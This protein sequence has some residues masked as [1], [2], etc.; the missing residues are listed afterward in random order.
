MKTDTKT[1]AKLRKLSTIVSLCI[2]AAI[3]L[4]QITLRI[5][6]KKK[7]EKLHD[8]AVAAAQEYLQTKYG[9]TT[10]LKDESEYP[11]RR[12]ILLRQGIHE[13]SAEYNGRS[14]YVWVNTNSEAINK[15]K[16]SYQFEDMYAEIKNRL[17]S[18]FPTSFIHYFWLGDDDEWDAS[19]LLYGGFSEYY[20]GSNL[21]DII[22]KCGKGG[23]KFCVANASFKDSDLPQMLSDLNFSY[24]L[25]AFDTEDHLNEFKKLVDSDSQLF[26]EYSQYK[27]AYPYITENINNLH[28]EISTPQIVLREAEDYVYSYLPIENAGFPVAADIAPPTALETKAFTELFYYGG[29]KTSPAY[30]EREY[31]DTPV[32]VPQYFECG[33]GDVMIY[34]PLEK[35][36]NYRIE[37]I[38]YAWYSRGGFSN[39]RNIEKPVIFGDYAVLRLQYGEMSFMLVDMSGKGEYTPGWAAK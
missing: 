15:C 7:A 9:F 6:E 36:K 2:I 20:D 18:E 34:Y 33:Y 3:L 19:M 13:F 4:G 21:D 31:V 28:G 25:T 17:Y 11:A 27:Y 32:S 24:C 1:N 29:S 37:D 8:H 23:I 39:N 38:S 16:D 30:D 10:N 35:L 14:F 5:I 12:N 22:K 26:T